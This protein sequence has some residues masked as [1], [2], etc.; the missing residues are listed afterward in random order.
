MG[1]LDTGDSINVG[2]L[3]AGW[4]AVVVAIVALCFKFRSRLF[5]RSNWQYQR[6]DPRAV[7][8]DYGILIQRS[9]K[10]TGLITGAAP[11]LTDW[12]RTAYDS[13]R[14]VT[15]TRPLHGLPAVETCGW[16]ELFRGCNITPS[17]LMDGLHFFRM[18]GSSLVEKT[19]LLV[20]DNS[21]SYGLTAGQFVA[22][23]VIC[24]FSPLEVSELRC[25]EG[26]L[27]KI[28][29]RDTGSPIQ[30]ATFRIKPLRNF[31]MSDDTLEE[32]LHCKV[33]VQRSID[34]ALGIIRMDSTRALGANT[35]IIPEISMMPDW[36]GRPSSHHVDRVLENLERMKGGSSSNVSVFDPYNYSHTLLPIFRSQPALFAAFALVNLQPWAA[37]PVLPIHFVDAFR[38]LVGFFATSRLDAL[39]EV[40]EILRLNRT[41]RP[42]FGWATMTEQANALSQY[43]NTSSPRLYDIDRPHWY[44]HRPYI[45]SWYFGSM[46]NLFQQL[47][48]SIDAVRLRTTV[49]AVFQFFAEV[50]ADGNKTD[51]AHFTNDLMQQLGQSVDAADVPDWAVQVYGKY[52]WWWLNDSI[53][54]DVDPF[55][56]IK[57]RVFLS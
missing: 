34:Y 11:S 48:I 45:L 6:I 39:S 57:P 14:Y 19:D 30:E 55:K 16:S 44:R 53:E 26:F 35:I 17:E 50:D 37:Y 51:E 10:R 36:S 3:V 25:A 27:G 32:Q 31:R 43:V 15:L 52:L 22:L 8:G 33:S 28:E 40:Q 2:A 38:P 9:V 56:G 54:I 20:R 21:I 49:I 29:L 18:T 42:S 41:I 4:A 24:G 47:Q 7:A 5:S 46:T 1:S 23:L 12:L 13:K